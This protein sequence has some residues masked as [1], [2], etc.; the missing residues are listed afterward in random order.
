MVR[1]V[2]SRIDP[3]MADLE[4][5]MWQAYYGKERVQLFALLVAELAWWVAHRTPGE[6]SPERAGLFALA[7]GGADN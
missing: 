5:R 6:E 4:L 7:N 3:R 1:H 2:R